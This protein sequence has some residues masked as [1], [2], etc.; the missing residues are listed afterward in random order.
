MPP[1]FDSFLR[2]DMNIMC[3]EKNDSNYMQLLVAS[4]VLFVVW[5]IM[6]PLFFLQLLLRIKKSIRL[7]RPS[8]LALSCSFLWRDYDKR[9]DWTIMW[10]FF[11]IL[12]RIFLTGF[13][14]YLDT[15]AGRSR[16]LRLVFG[17]LVSLLMTAANVYVK[18]Y[19][20]GDDQLL[21][22]VSNVI[23][24]A[25]FFLS[26]PLNICGQDSEGKCAEF[27]HGAWTEK[28]ASTMVAVSAFVMLVTTVAILF[29]MSQKVPI[30][31]LRKTKYPPN[32]EMPTKNSFHFFMSHSW[33]GAQDITHAITRKM[34]LHLPSL[35]I[36]LDVDNLLSTGD[37]EKFIE[38]SVVIVIVY[39]PGYFRSK[40]CRREFFQ[41]ILLKKPII[42]LYDGDDDKLLELVQ[43][44]KEFALDETIIREYVQKRFS[45]AMTCETKISGFTVPT[46]EENILNKRQLVNAE[47]SITYTIIRIQSH[48]EIF[49]SKCT[50]EDIESN[51]VFCTESDSFDVLSLQWLKEGQ[52]SSESLKL[53]YLHLLKELPYSSSDDRRQLL[54]A[55]IDLPDDSAGR[56]RMR[57]QLTITQN[58]S[59]E[60]RI[61]GC[62]N[63]DVQE[64]LMESLKRICPNITIHREVENTAFPI[65]VPLSHMQ[66]LKHSYTDPTNEE[67]L[68]KDSMSDSQSFMS[69]RSED[70]SIFIDNGFEGK[71]TLRKG[72]EEIP[73]NPVSLR[74][75]HGLDRSWV[76]KEKN[77]SRF[78]KK[79]LQRRNVNAFVLYLNKDTFQ[80]SETIL[81]EIQEIKDAKI[82]IILVHEK[83]IERGACGFEL[84]FNQVPGSFADEIFADI[85]IPLYKRK[86]YREISLNAIVEAL[87]SRFVK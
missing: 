66:S 44:C 85:A 24:T 9:S 21:S 70:S 4:N 80:S 7:Y 53:I 51:E 36:W 45:S 81:N 61:L 12:R 32:V 17:G 28:K 55:G 18:P 77:G 50:G 14:N 27:V 48:V 26:I 76:M 47:A 69:Y 73:T 13:M 20:R 15:K 72:Y 79:D 54:D 39:S 67:C 49:I 84:F 33:D 10:E 86:E 83:D 78:F 22:S 23:V 29:A 62:N 58:V 19:Q 52:Y 63:N 68:E 59:I 2:M 25:T 37:L 64:G 31:R 6:V 75:L 3:D 5:S 34:K 71:V 82:P 56:K 35:Q 16:I 1:D 60:L 38:Q 65:N 30:S 8:S 43:E 41:A 74:S 40:N 57:N 46:D 87:L 11:E 42:V